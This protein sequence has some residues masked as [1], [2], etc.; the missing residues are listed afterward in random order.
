MKYCLDC[1]LCEFFSPCNCKKWV[2]NPLLNFSIHAKNHQVSSVNAPAWYCKRN[3]KCE[4]T[5][6][7]QLQLWKWQVGPFTKL[8]A[9]IYSLLKISVRLFCLLFL[10]HISSLRYPGQRC[11]DVTTIDVM[12]S[13][14]LISW[15]HYYWCHDVTTIDESIHWY[16]RMAILVDISCYTCLTTGQ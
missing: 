4:W 12:T 16:E 13:L 6:K 1:L 10:T 11:H 14:L 3:R 5:L 9:W 15:R 8:A 7:P 2:Q